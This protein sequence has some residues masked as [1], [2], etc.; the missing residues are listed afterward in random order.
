MSEPAS[1][2]PLA[3]DAS[4]RRYHRGRLPD[5]DTVVV[6]EAGEPGPFARWAAFYEGLGLRVPRVLTSDEERLFNLGRFSC[7]EEGR[8]S[9]Y[10]IRA[11]GWGS[12]MTILFAA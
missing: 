12:G 2:S 10:A 5:G 7:F 9:A 6:M 11:G 3:G 8:F 1:L 4:T